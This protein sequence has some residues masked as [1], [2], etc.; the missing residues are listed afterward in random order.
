MASE[1]LQEQGLR[2]AVLGVKALTDFRLVINLT[3]L[4]KAC[5]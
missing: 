2:T 5:P 3:A 4:N 1:A